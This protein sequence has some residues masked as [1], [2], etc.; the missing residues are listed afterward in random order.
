MARRNP[1]QTASPARN[2]T[3]TTEERVQAIV[4][5]PPAWARRRKRIEDLSEQIVAL[6]REGKG[7]EV[8]KAL[9]E[10]GKLVQAHNTYYPIEANL[11]LDPETSRLMDLGVPWK[12]L[13]R[14]TLEALLAEAARKESVPA[15][16]AWSDAAGALSVSFDA[17]RDGEEDR[18][19]VR[20]D[21]EALSCSASPGELV[22]VPTPTIEEI[23]AG[24][25]LEIVTY[26]SE[27]VALPFA[28]EASLLATLA[29]ELGA[30]L[31][32]LRAT[33]SGYRGE[34]RED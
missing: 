21:H 19:T 30:R 25:T 24:P 4:T 27:T 3:L 14:P 10:L 18:F 16:L 13:P 6:H 33:G 8:T 26:Q 9:A 20:L 7:R 17:T 11:P 32:L 23:L 34:P 2:F 15:S 1:E 28:L 22:R 29:A 12:P 5:G 31:R